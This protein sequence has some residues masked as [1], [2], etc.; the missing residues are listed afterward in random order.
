[1]AAC[2]RTWLGGALDLVDRVMLSTWTL[3]TPGRRLFDNGVGDLEMLDAAE[4]D[5]RKIY[6]GEMPLPCVTDLRWA[7][8][9]TKNGIVVEEATFDAPLAQYLPKESARAHFQ[10]V[11]PVKV[12]DLK[13]IAIH[14]QMTADETFAW[15]RSMVAEELVR[16]G[17]ASILLMVPFY[18]TRRPQ[19]QVMHY[20]RTVADCLTGGIVAMLEAA[21]LAEWCKGQFPGIPVCL[22]GQSAGAA[23]AAG[24]ALLCSG[25]VACVP[26]IGPSSGRPF[27]NGY[28]SV[29]VNWNRLAASIGVNSKREARAYL[30]DLFTRKSMIK[31]A[32]W[33]SNARRPESL[34]VISVAGINDGVVHPVD[35]LELHQV[36]SIF[37]RYTEM[38][39]LRGGHSVLLLSRA[40]FIEAIRDAI[41]IVASDGRARP[42]TNGTATSVVELQPMKETS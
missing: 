11:R 25:N 33:H 29:N 13:G 15:R 7:A 42:S 24:G 34:T 9:S 23:P 40:S 12:D 28:M 22:T 16:S 19:G 41:S 10:F 39:W 20:Y 30:R 2:D 17:I 35:S 5:V 26:F 36:L 31:L 37:S 4:E 38:R 18:G 8:V 3:L 27:C 32:D 14:S 1:M 21:M 6:V